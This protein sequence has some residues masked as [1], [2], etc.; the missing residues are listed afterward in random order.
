MGKEIYLSVDKDNMTGGIQ[1]SINDGD[2]GYRLAGPKYSGYSETLKR[3]T[4]T[5]ED[6]AQIRAY[7]RKVPK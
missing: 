7:L 2:G 3:H 5:Q 1:I 6:V 4:L